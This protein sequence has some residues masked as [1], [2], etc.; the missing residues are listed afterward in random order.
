MTELVD[1]WKAD[2]VFKNTPPTFSKTY[3]WLSSIPIDEHNIKQEPHTNMRFRQAVPTGKKQTHPNDS[4][5][6][7]QTLGIPQT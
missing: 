4:S 5:P 3:Y 7:T 1:P 6:K 2:S